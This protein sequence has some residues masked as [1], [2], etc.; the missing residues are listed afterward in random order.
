M[1]TPIRKPLAEISPAQRAAVVR[2]IVGA[3]PLDVAAFNS[4]I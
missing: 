1:A 4:A 3:K 2:R